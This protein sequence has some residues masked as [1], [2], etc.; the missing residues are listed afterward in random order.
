MTYQNDTRVSRP[1]KISIKIK[2]GRWTQPLNPC[3][4]KLT[5][6]RTNP[7]SETVFK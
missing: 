2:Y 4:I 7:T 3:R 5:K 6:V 1:D